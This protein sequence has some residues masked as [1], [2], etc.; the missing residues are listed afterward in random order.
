MGSSSGG[1]NMLSKPLNNLTFSLK[2]F[3]FTLWEYHPECGLEEKPSG[4]HQN[5]PDSSTGEQEYT[6][7]SGCA[8]LNSRSVS[9]DLDGV[10]AVL[11]ET[12]ALQEGTVVTDLHALTGEVTSLE[13][14]DAVVLSVLM[15]N[16]RKQ[17]ISF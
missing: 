11:G 3:V 6:V 1:M 16:Q 9:V 7:C 13:H 2:Y 10:D 14:L 12:T 15:E 17:N 5:N 4:G 8:V